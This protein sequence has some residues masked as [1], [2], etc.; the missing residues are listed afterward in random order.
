MYQFILDQNVIQCPRN[1]RS[2]IHPPYIRRAPAHYLVSRAMT[3]VPI[4]EWH[5]PYRWHFPMLLL[6]RRCHCSQWLNRRNVHRPVEAYQIL[7]PVFLSYH[8]TEKL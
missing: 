3:P 5:V 1:T 2:R 7:W 6:F 4:V 8:H